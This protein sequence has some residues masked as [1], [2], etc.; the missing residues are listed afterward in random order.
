[1][2]GAGNSPEKAAFFA[3]DIQRQSLDP[4]SKVGSGRFTEAPIASVNGVRHETRPHESRTYQTL[5]VT[6]PAQ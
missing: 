6:P 2:L 4:N 5:Y 3:Q 1:M